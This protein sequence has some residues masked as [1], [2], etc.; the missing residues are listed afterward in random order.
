MLML[1]TKDPKMM[2]K[3]RQE[4]DEVFSPDHE[5]TKQMLLA[6]PEKLQ[7]IPYTNA[8]IR[9]TLRLFP[10]GIPLRSAEEGSTIPYKGTEYPLGDSR[11][12]IALNGHD[13]HYNSD[14]FPS[15]AS[16]KPERWLDDQNQ[17]PRSY[18]RTFS[19]GARACLGMNLAINEL[20]VVLIMV[21]RDFDFRCADLK[22][23]LQAKTSYTTLDTEFGDVI[24]QEVGLEAKPRGPMMM[25]TK[26]RKAERDRILFC[27]V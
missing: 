27:Q 15:A 10:V 5:T 13:L 22:P 12:V 23:N 6:N 19:R 8:I 7:E 25:L 20:K 1:L 14:Y 3:M 26:K 21:I 11:F 18:F 9:E 16:F 24:F 17:V 4:H 2:A